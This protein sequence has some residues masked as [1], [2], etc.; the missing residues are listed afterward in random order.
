M[1]FQ[2]PSAPSPASSRVPAGTIRSGVVHVNTQHTTH[3][4]VVG[5]HLAQHRELSLTAIGL[6]L[7]IQS[8]P[9]GARV[10]IQALAGRFPEGESRIATALRELEAHGYLERSRVR[11]GDGRIVTRTVSYNHPKGTPPPPPPPPG[12]RAP[13]A[14]PAEPTTVPKPDPQPAAGPLP[15]PAPGPAREEPEPEGPQPASDLRPAPRSE[16]APEP[17]PEPV[18]E[19]DLSPAS[20][21]D[22]GPEAGGPRWR[23]AEA[24]L[25]R[26]RE[27]DHRLLLS[28]SSVRQLAPGVA[29]WLHRGAAPE[30]V[31]MVLAADLPPDL[32]H[33]AA[34]LGYRLRS[35]R[36]PRLSAVP[37]AAAPSSRP[38]PM[39]NCDG[40]DRGFRAP[41][42]GRCADC[43]PEHEAL[44]AA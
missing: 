12:D 42:P 31:R 30:A 3:Y 14:D 27:D 16:S 29:D 5:N 10:G 4:T 41:A 2:H 28:E 15:Q 25:A 7:H 34:L 24:L 17:V 13:V 1:A 36:P 19:P 44:A 40:C 18:P 32:R 43:P 22:P 26:L 39:Q 33:P 38:D 11:I 37:A 20:D 6:A 9:T 8:L 23:E 35:S 21:P